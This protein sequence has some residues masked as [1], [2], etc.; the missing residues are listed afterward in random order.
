MEIISATAL[1][2]SAGMRVFLPLLL[3]T[4]AAN[5]Y[6]P[7]GG[8]GLAELPP[9]MAWLGTPYALAVAAVLYA[10]ERLAYFV[11]VV[12]HITDVVKT[13]LAPLAGAVVAMAALVQPS[14]PETVSVLMPVAALSTTGVAEVSV[15]TGLIALAVGGIPALIMHGAMAIA[16]FVLNLMYAGCLGCLS[17]IASVFE[18]VGAIIV[19]ILAL[20]LPILALALLTGLAAFLVIKWM[21]RK[22]RPQ[23]A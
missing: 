7:L 15:G 21:R 4:L 8:L 18:D 16:R 5:G 23:A 2:S 17:P 13:F 14:V 20:V 3:L 22:Q 6:L 10:I 11:P 1:G 9:S 12:D 19:F